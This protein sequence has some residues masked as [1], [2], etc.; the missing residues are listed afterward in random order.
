MVVSKRL[1]EYNNGMSQTIGYARV[2]SVGQSLD[3]QLQKL[4]EAGCTRTFSEKKSGRQF[5]GRPQ[6]QACLGYVREGDVLVITRLDRMGRSLLD[7]AKTV[8]ALEKK[9]VRLRV[10]DQA[11]DTSTSEGRLMLGLLGAFAQFEADIRAERQADGIALAKAK[12][13][14]FGRKVALNDAQK[15]TIQ[16]LRRE[17]GFSVGR[18]QERFQVGRATIYRALGE[19]VA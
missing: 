10:L 11:L 8:D 18:L 7:L 9:G 14:R 19:V 12:G 13:V 4:S 3:V 17:E 6:L 1:R 5:E 2:S 15:A 16:R